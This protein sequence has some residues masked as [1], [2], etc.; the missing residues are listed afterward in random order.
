[1]YI[2]VVSMLCVK[3]LVLCLSTVASSQGPEFAPSESMLTPAASPPPPEMPVAVPSQSKFD[4][5]VTDLSL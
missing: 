1:M 4:L 3:H 5:F 2:C